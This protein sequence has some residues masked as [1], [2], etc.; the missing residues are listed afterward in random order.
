MTIIIRR[1]IME[2]I[3]R[4]E[5]RFHLGTGFGGKK[6][7]LIRSYKTGFRY[8]PKCERLYYLPQDLRCPYGHRIRLKPRYN[9]SRKHLEVKRIRVTATKT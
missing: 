5:L 8:C 4:K 9:V 3:R 2:K 1:K 7:Y 6:I